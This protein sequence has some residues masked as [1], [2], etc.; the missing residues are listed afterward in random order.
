MPIK[1]TLRDG[2]YSFPTDLGAELRLKN[3]RPDKF[4][5]L[6]AEDA[7]FVTTEGAVLALS[8]GELKSGR[9]RR[10]LITQ[11]AA[12]DGADPLRWE[13]VVMEAV[14]ALESDPHVMSQVV[15][16]PRPQLVTIR[17]FLASVPPP[18]PEVDK[19]LLEHGPLW[20]LLPSQRS[21]SR[22]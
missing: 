9:C 19:G 15:S 22:S 21:L 20:G 4:G 8:Q 16:A 17:E 10:D 11:A 14:V 5:R 18:R 13:N 3:V 7:R 12:R 6:F 2:V 1:Y